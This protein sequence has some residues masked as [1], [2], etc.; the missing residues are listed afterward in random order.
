MGIAQ[1]CLIRWGPIQRHIWFECGSELV[2]RLVEGMFTL[3]QL[4][5]TKL[6]PPPPA[7]AWA[8]S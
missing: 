1:V 3:P 8:R 7:V 5:R 4:R 6:L 2:E